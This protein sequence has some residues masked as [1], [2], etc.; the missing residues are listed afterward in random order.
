MIAFQGMNKPTAIVNG[1]ACRVRCV[2]KYFILLSLGRM[3]KGPEAILMN[4]NRNKHKW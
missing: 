4:A 3:E 2:V 1:V